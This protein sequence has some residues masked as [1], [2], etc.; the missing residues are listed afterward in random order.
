MRPKYEIFRIIDYF[1]NTDPGHKSSQHHG[2]EFKSLQYALEYSRKNCVSF[3][4]YDPNNKPL[5]V[6]FDGK[7]EMNNVILPFE[8]FQGLSMMIW[9]SNMSLQLMKDVD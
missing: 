7:I 3:E 4:H 6:N 2:D 8:I 9:I 1:T 5:T